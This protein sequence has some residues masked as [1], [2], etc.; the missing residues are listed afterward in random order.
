MVVKKIPSRLAQ[1]IVAVYLDPRAIVGYIKGLVVKKWVI[2]A[3]M[4]LLTVV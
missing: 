3:I 1:Q 4:I 2:Y